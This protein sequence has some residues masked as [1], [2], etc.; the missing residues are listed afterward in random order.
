MSAVQWSLGKAHLRRFHSETS[1]DRVV[2][3][4]ATPVEVCGARGQI[5]WL[6]RSR[7]SDGTAPFVDPRR[8]HGSRAGNVGSG[9]RCGRVVDLYKVVCPKKTHSIYIS[10]YH[11]TA[12]QRFP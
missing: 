9:G 10:L 1:L 2:T 6:L 7:C 11:C 5:A 3:T 8:A 4:K 12:G